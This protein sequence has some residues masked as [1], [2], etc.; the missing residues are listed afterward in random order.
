MASSKISDLPSATLPLDGTGLVP[1]VQGGGTKKVT[2]T[3]LRE[4][5]PTVVLGSDLANSTT[6]A[7]TGLEVTGLVA[8]TYNFKA[9]ICF[10][11]AATTTGL[12]LYMNYTGTAT[13]LVSTWYTLTTGTTATTGVADQSSDNTA[14][15]MEGKA[16]RANNTSTGTIQGVDTA[17]ADQ[18]CVMEGILV[19][20]GAGALRLRFSSEVAASAVTLMTGTN[21]DVR[22]V[23]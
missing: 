1:I 5:Y 8:G 6:T 13:R 7:A 11:S 12:M 16:Q 20:S 15:M 2:V 14:Q 18:F 10:R 23:A 9:W 4:A 19:A 22:K 17:N 21:L 3:N